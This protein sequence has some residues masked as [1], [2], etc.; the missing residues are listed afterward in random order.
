M[1]RLFWIAVGVLL[2]AAGQPAYADR[3]LALPL[4]APSADAHSPMLVASARRS[5]V[6]VEVSQDGQTLQ[7]RGVGRR[8]RLNANTLR[9][10]VL[11]AV[12]CDRLQL[13]D[14]QTLSGS[15]FFPSVGINS[16]TGE[17]AVGVMLRE[18]V[19]TQV[20]AVVVLRPQRNGYAWHLVQVPGAAALPDDRSTYP[21]NSITALGY[22]NDDLLIKQ[23]DASGSEAMLVFTPSNSTTREFAGCV[24]TQREG[25]DRLCPPSR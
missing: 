18:C 11:D 5:A 16:Q 3:P 21:L 8:Y 22:L 6:R 15:W 1:K 10:Q 13:A 17:V 4:S 7:I 24:Y 19:E 9:V 14:R 12:D 2:A 20:S 25:G 23:G